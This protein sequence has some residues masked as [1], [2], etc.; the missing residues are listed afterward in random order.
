VNATTAQLSVIPSHF[1]HALLHGPIA[2]CN[3]DFSL[4]PNTKK[5]LIFTKTRTT[6]SHV[7]VIKFMV[8]LFVIHSFGDQQLGA[9]GASIAPTQTQ[10]FDKSNSA[11]IHSQTEWTSHLSF[12]H[13]DDD[14]KLNGR[15]LVTSFSSFIPR[16][17][18]LWQKSAT[19]RVPTARSVGYA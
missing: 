5:R 18:Y 9:I 14:E 6:N 4:N 13:Y 1:H 15:R 16:A 19:V 12:S 3:W 17:F 7:A 11:E 2:I 10:K 8:D